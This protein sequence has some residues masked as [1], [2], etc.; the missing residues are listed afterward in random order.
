MRV[1]R[2]SEEE[3]VKRG[4]DT[5]T[6]QKRYLVEEPRR[7][8]HLEQIVNYQGVLQLKG[9]S[10]LHQLRAQDFHHVHVAQTDEQGGER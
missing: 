4:G 8:H 1:V 2:Q 6:K 9:F 10:I 5:R 7:E 3:E